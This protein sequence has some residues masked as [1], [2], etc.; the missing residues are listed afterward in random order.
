M[1]YRHAFHAGNFADVLKHVVLSLCCDR[2]GQK[3]KP[4]RYID[5]HGGA[6]LYDLGGEEAQRSPEW[7]YGVARVL[8]AVPSAPES[9]REALAP[10][11]AAISAANPDGGRRFYPGS[12]LIAASLMRAGDRLRLA[13]RHE[14]TAEMLACAFAGDRRVKVEARDGFEALSA[15]LPPPERRG[16]VLVDPP[17]EEGERERK[18]DFPR[19]I[20]AARRALRRWPGGVYLFWRPLKYPDAVEAFD[21]EL[22]CALIEEGGLAPDRLLLVD[23]WVRTPAPD[24]PLGG[25]GLIVVNPP[26]GLHDRLEALMPWLTAA[27]E[28]RRGE[29]GFRLAIPVAADQ[30]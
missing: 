4:Y 9:V 7:R 24:G 19:M 16:L 3:E 23:Q 8:E 1:N 18:K 30:A 22:A 25:A 2:L 26:Y 21:S 12:P 11:L 15:Y 20:N 10:W 29:G 6:G 14:P 27:M 28:D 17:F 5:T 13:E